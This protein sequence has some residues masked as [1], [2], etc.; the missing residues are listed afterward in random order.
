M[1]RKNQQQN[2]VNN[3]KVGLKANNKKQAIAM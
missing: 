3:K 2:L 1:V